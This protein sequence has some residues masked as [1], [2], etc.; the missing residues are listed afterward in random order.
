LS[1][2]A[3]EI[4]SGSIDFTVVQNFAIA[5]Q[6]GTTTLDLI[7]SPEPG[8]IFIFCGGLAGIAL[9]RRFRKA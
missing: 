5:V 1:N 8:T 2:L 3:T 7:I 6:T 9:L 4:A